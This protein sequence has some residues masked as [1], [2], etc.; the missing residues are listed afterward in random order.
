ML[1]YMNAHPT[2]SVFFAFAGVCLVLVLCNFVRRL[3]G[4]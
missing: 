2:A 3:A 1:D 4:R